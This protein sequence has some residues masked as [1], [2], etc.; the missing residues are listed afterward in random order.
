MF[1][2]IL[3]CAQEVYRMLNGIFQNGPSCM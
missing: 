1:V 3:F 2:N